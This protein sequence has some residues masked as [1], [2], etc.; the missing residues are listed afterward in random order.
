MITM[1]GDTHPGQ[2]EHNED[3]FIADASLGLGL[4]ADGMGG[5]EAGEVASQLVVDVIRAK[6][7]EFPPE[8]LEVSQ[9]V[10]KVVTELGATSM[11]DMGKVMKII[12]GKVQGKADN[13]LVSELVKRALSQL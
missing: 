13:K 10:D 8:K 5:H 3:C 1:I 2:R 6:V 12:T 4:V 11:K 9:I 7:E